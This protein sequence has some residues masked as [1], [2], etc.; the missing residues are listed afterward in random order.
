MSVSRQK[1]G[2]ALFAGVLLVAAALTG[3]VACGGSGGT[4]EPVRAGDPSLTTDVPGQIPDTGNP[5]GDAG[6]ISFEVTTSGNEPTTKLLVGVGDPMAFDRLNVFENGTTLRVLVSDSAGQESNLGISV[7]DW[8]PGQRHVIT[9]T[10]GGDDQEVYIDG[11]LIGQV[12]H[13][14][15]FQL[16]PGT[17]V[18][19]GPGGQGVPPAT[20]VV[21][22]F[23]VFKRPL[24]PQE[25]AMFYG[26][27]VLSSVATPTAVVPRVE[28]GAP[29]AALRVQSTSPTAPESPGTVCVELTGSDGIIA[30]TQNDLVWDP[31]CLTIT[32]PCQANPQHGKSVR[33]GV[34]NQGRLRTIVFSLT[35]TNPIDDGLLYC[36]PYQVVS[37]PS[38]GCCAVALQAVLGS[39]SFGDAIPMDGIAG[40]VCR[41]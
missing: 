19:I 6:T 28:P 10:W 21:S 3:L 41:P 11:Q 27:A 32:T 22:N 33:T 12:G 20:E 18:Y 39:D 35:D 40:Q 34:P 26:P 36:C 38:G 30:G 4:Q 23:H 1:E 29:E 15:D 8:E 25:V 7:A 14:S 17:P 24:T 16:Q 5:R 13:L 9:F 2:A 31:A 37:L